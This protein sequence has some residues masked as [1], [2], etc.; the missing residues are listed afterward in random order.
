MSQRRVKS[1]VANSGYS[2][3]GS[4]REIG[5]ARWEVASRFG[6][7]N[8]DCSF[9]FVGDLLKVERARRF[10]IQK[11]LMV[12]LAATGLALA[13]ISG[14]VAAPVA[15]IGKAADAIDAR[16]TVHYYGYS[17]HRHHRHCWWRYG[18]RICRW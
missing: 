7:K 15:P 6:N 14:A 9:N 12:A 11:F 10:L 17:Y 18:G 2:V 4:G 16:S 13:A 5:Y 8:Q 3:S 1:R